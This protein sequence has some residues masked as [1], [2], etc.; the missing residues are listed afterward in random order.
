ME[1]HRTFIYA[2]VIVISIGITF[3]TT[4]SD[5]M[6]GLGTVFIAIG[7]LLLIAGMS[8]KRAAEKSDDD[9]EA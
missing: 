2:A 4:M 6:G 3:N 5:S 1:S 7:G 9:S 8:R